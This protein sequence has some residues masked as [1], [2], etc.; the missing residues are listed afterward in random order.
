MGDKVEPRFAVVMTV[1]NMVKYIPGAIASILPELVPDGELIV[2]DA[3]STDGTTEFLRELA[4]AGSLRLIVEPCTRGRG[5]HLGVLA[6]KAPIVLTQV[7][8]DLKYYPGV[9]RTV[10]KEFQES[11][12]KGFMVAFG[13]HDLNP[14]G[15][16][17]FVWERSCYLDTGGYPDINTYEEMFLLSKVLATTPARRYLV[18]KVAEDLRVEMWQRS[19]SGKVSQRL[20]GTVH[21]ARV[22]H[23]SGWTYRAYIRF[24]WLT[25]RTVAGF[26]AGSALSTLGFV[27]PPIRTS[28]DFL[29]DLTPR[30]T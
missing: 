21:V 4:E 1:R 6:S 2:V 24:L 12:G 17:I 22:R 19:E 20:K 27:L 10:V 9:I 16:K 14:G 18:E 3:A 13:R 5:R 15:A 29:Y 8:A 25:H 26:L 7:D 23:G 28:K 11:G 30:Q